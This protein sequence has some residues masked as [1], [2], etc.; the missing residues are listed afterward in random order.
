MFDLKSYNDNLAC[1]S[2][3]GRQLTYG[4]LEELARHV[5][6]QME[7]HRLVFCLCSNTIGSIVGYVAFL[8]NN[9]ATLLLENGMNREAF[10]E[11]LSVYR[12]SYIWAPI[13]SRLVFYGEKLLEVE[14]Y[15]LLKTGNETPVANDLAVMLATS[16]STGSPKVVRLT[17][18]NLRC[19]AESIIGF[20]H[21]TSKE[22]PILGLPMNY[23]FG[24][25]VINSHLM[26]GATLLLTE[27]SFVEREFVEFAIDNGFTSYSGVPFAYKTIMK[28][29]LWR[30][31]MPSLRT[32]TMAG[33]MPDWEVVHFFDNTLR[34]LGKKLYVMYG[35][36]EATARIAY[37]EPEFISKKPGSIGKCISGGEI[38]LE[39]EDGEVINSPFVKGELV[40]RG[41]NVSLGYADSAEDLTRGDD[42]G[43]VIHTGDIGYMDADGYYFITGRKGRFV[44][45]F[46]IR[47]SLDHIE[48]LLQP[49]LTDCACVGDDEH[50]TVYTTDKSEK[51][52]DEKWNE[53]IDKI[54]MRTKIPR[55]SF[56]VYQIDKMPRAK[57]GKVQYANLINQ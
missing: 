57:S 24:L 16:G 47:M 49:L 41:K 45:L 31:Q 27:K 40:Y 38:W 23:A 34:P 29:S 30:Q 4:E 53:V 35:Q 11:L 6:S 33:G 54:S 17:K 12:P 28:L 50:I 37:L 51:W 46:G 10:E 22:R 19:N 39:G 36:A 18:N 5:C 55:K 13:N 32:L 48:T 3:N 15:A 42:N 44:K 8:K 26:K 52:N 9:D 20:L 1:I 43:G 7:A 21:I 2:S 25:S 56:S 14:G